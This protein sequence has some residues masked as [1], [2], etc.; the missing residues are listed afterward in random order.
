MNPMQQVRIEK[1]TLNFGAGSDQPLLEKGFKLLERLS[2][3]KVVKTV[4]MKRIPNWNIRPNLP[5]GAKV[6]L[7][8]ASAL[9]FLKAALRARENKLPLRSIDKEGNFSFGIKEYIDMDT[10]E[11]D[12]ALGILGFEIAV[13]MEKPGFRIKRRSHH[14]KSLPKRS[15]IKPQEVS[16]FMKNTFNTSFISEDDE[17]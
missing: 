7:R 8:G 16:E 10:I 17:Q 14:K 13:T 3:K 4:S 11:Y 1:I 15:I 2:K 5:I 12:S 6:T 9:E